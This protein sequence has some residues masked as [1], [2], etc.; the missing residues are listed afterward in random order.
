MLT[1]PKTPDL[2]DHVD[3]LKALIA[4][5]DAKL[6]ERDEKIAAQSHTIDLLTRIA[7]GRSSEKRRSP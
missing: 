7:F 2:P 6:A 3:T 4:E 1:K 5:R